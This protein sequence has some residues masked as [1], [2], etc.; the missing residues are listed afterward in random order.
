MPAKAHSEVG[1]GAQD[2]HRRL[3]PHRGQ[4]ALAHAVQN[5]SSFESL[6]LLGKNLLNYIPIIVR[7]RTGPACFVDRMPRPEHGPL[8]L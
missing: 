5:Q 8:V 3:A 6:S 7:V 1:R 2:A 4:G